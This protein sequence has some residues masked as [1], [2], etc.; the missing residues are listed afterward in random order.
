MKRRNFLASLFALPF[1]ALSLEALQP[2]SGKMSKEEI[3]RFIAGLYDDHRKAIDANREYL[4]RLTEAIVQ[5]APTG[6]K[7]T[8]YKYSAE[9]VKALGRAVRRYKKP[10]EKK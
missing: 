10:P 4:R 6:F 7:K 5:N 2:K 8:S 1:A 9:D 3:S